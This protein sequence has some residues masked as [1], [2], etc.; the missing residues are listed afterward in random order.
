MFF[1]H[2]IPTCLHFQNLKTYKTAI[3]H[4]WESLCTCASS[5][6]SIS[7]WHLTCGGYLGV[8]FLSVFSN[9]KPIQSQTLGSTELTSCM[10]TTTGIPIVQVL[11]S[12]SAL[13]WKKH[14]H[15]KLVK[16]ITLLTSLS[17]CLRH[18]SLNMLD[19]FFPGKNIHKIN[20]K[21]FCEIYFTDK[22]S[23]ISTV[24]LTI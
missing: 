3:L 21:S 2:F 19:W 11:G 9:L 18:T 4:T 16:C 5:C 23:F 10:H 14:I 13:L 7:I 12:N 20:I 8:Y 6:Y 22:E 17:S 15:R 1:R 24:P